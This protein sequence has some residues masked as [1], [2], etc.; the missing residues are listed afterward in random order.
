MHSN[1]YGSLMF[2]SYLSQFS[3]LICHCHL[4]ARIHHARKLAIG[5]TE[6]HI[7]A[8]YFLHSRTQTH[9][10]LQKCNKYYSE[11]LKTRRNCVF[12]SA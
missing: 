10:E 9:N 4:I 2:I 3:V 1:K 6:M 11:N 12:E 5:S 7:R 8:R